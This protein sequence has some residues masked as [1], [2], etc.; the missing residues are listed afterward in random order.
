MIIY[1]RDRQL[2]VTRGPILRKLK[3]S[4]PGKESKKKKKKVNQNMFFN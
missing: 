3:S 2:K 4:E 1:D